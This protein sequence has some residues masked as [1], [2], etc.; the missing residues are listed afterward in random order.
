MQLDNIN[1][2]QCNS[3]EETDIINKDMLLLK[4]MYEKIFKENYHLRKRFLEY[5]ATIEKEDED[6]YKCKNVNS[7]PWL[8]FYSG[9]I[10]LKST[11]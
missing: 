2:S 6:L 1:N 8:N 9:T 11:T 10:Q 4:C 7:S 5:G 3:C